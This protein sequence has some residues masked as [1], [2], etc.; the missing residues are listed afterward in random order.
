MQ[1]YFLGKTSNSRLET[2]CRDMRLFIRE[3][4]RTTTRHV[5]DWGVV[6]GGRGKV[7]QKKAR[8]GGNSDADWGESDHN[9][10]KGDKLDSP[11]VDV[12]PYCPVKQDY[13]WND[14]EAFK[15]LHGHLLATASR[16]GYTIKC[17]VTLKSGKRDN[18]HIVLLYKRL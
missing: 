7:A 5:G 3:A 9:I 10:M 14:R 12:A 6:C 2:C 17:G 15:R 16:M 11:A 4:M 1:I 8:L 13:M 18:P